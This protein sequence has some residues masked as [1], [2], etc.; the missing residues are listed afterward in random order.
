MSTVQRPPERPIEGYEAV[1]DEWIEAVAALMKEAER[2]SVARGW[3]VS[4][5]GKQIYEP[6]LGSYELSRILIDTGNGRVLLDPVARYV[7]GLEGGAVDLLSVPDYDGW[8]I[9]REWG[10]WSFYDGDEMVGGKA[11][12]EETFARAVDRM[13]KP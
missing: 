3:K 8:L 5:V 10:K 4:H 1:R 12:A 11:W 2:W 7:S 9:A 6:E 13:A